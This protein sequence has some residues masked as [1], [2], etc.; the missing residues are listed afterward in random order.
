[1]IPRGRLPPA[2]LSPK[3]EEKSAWR[4]RLEWRRLRPIVEVAP[5]SFRQMEVWPRSSFVSYLDGNMDFLED[6]REDLYSTDE[7]QVEERSRV[8]DDVPHLASHRQESK[9]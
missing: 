4:Q 1:M 7:D 3:P 9:E 5:S 8:G 6:A 2:H